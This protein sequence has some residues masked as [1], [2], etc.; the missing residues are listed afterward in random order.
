MRLRLFREWSKRSWFSRVEVSL[1][2]V[3]EL[4]VRRRCWQNLG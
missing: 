2:R 4:V 1:I 3:G